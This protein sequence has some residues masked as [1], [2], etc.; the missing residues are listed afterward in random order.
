MF[1]AKTG[2][3]GTKIFG[4]RPTLCILDDLV[5]DDDA[6]S[7]TSMQAIKD[8]VY[9]GV[10]PALD[11]TRRKVIFNGTPFNKDDIIIEAV[12]SGAWDVNVWPVCERFPCEP[13]EFVGAWE[14]R[15]SFAFVKEQYDLMAQSGKLAAFLSRVHVAYYF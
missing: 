2:I 1:G 9:K 7:P 11:P 12:E 13:E 15:F 6:K 8:T 14:D 5:S 4:K 10:F 3:R